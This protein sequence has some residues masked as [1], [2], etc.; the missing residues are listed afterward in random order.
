MSKSMKEMMTREYQSVYAGVEGACVVDL[1]GMD[2][3]GTH[4]LRGLLRDRQM[5]LRVV[6]NRIA[7][8]AFTGGP[9][10]P[11]GSHLE[12]PCALVIGE[13]VIDIAKELVEVARKFPALKLGDG[14]MEGDL[15]ITPVQELAKMKTLAEIRADLVGLALSPGRNL[16]GAIQAGGGRIAGCLKTIIEKLEKGETVGRAA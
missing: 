7:R 6:K 2:A 8:R 4:A 14:L 13:S 15:E 5:R 9:L 10:A 11:L 12:G 3:G 16:A 1:T